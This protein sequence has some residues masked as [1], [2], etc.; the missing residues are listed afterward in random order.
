M[1]AGDCFYGVLPGS[2]KIPH[3]WLVLC[4]PCPAGFV[5][6]VNFTTPNGS[7]QAHVVKQGFFPTLDYDSEVA[8]SYA[9]VWPVDAIK[10]AVAAGLFSQEIGL[11]AGDLDTVLKGGSDRG[12]I[13]REVLKKISGK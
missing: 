11:N 13:S 5:A 10:K 1:T 2:G 9:A 8:W 6:V 3:Y 4:A 12:L 7:P